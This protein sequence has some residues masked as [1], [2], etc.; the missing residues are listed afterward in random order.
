MVIVNVELGRM[1]KEGINWGLFYGTV[2]A[3]ILRN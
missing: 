1:W 2:P 3:F